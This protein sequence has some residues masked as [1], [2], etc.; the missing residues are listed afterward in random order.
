[1]AEQLKHSIAREEETPLDSAVAKGDVNLVSSL[2]DE[3]ATPESRGFPFSNTLIIA[4]KHGHVAVVNVLLEKNA[5]AHLESRE[6]PDGY[7][8][9]MW[10][11]MKGFD[12]IITLLLN[13]NANPYQ[14]LGRFYGKQTAL[15]LA[16]R[17]RQT[18]TVVLFQAIE[19][20]VLF[21]AS[22]KN[23]INLIQELLLNKKIDP[24]TK[25]EH[26]ET[27]LH[28]A[29][30]KGHGE[31]VALLI[32]HKADL[33]VTGNRDTALGMTP[34]HYAISE[35]KENC[36]MT[37]LIDHK[38]ELT[39]LDAFGNTP[40]QIA[41]SK[42]YDGTVEMLIRAKADVNTPNYSGLTPLHC[43]ARDGKTTTV[44]TLLKL[45]ADITASTA[46][47]EKIPRTA[48]IF[49]AAAGH[50]NIVQLLNQERS[51]QTHLAIFSG[52]HERTGRTE[53]KLDAAQ[54]ATL[55]RDA[56]ILAASRRPHFDK[57]IFE[58]PLKLAGFPLS[59]SVPKLPQKTALNLTTDTD[60]E[61]HSNDNRQE[62]SL[63]ARK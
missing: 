6:Y 34:L 51:R 45:R 40:L 61:H 44:K 30:R 16:F 5:S 22:E 29:A 21:R 9:L 28:Y 27:A 39:A 32:S 57:N 48:H 41:A 18:S 24:N 12:E 54:H 25:N 11:A 20:N 43:A 38:A 35:P 15:D 60:D 55:G 33:K 36:A 47:F 62:N 56:P 50:A 4:V 46:L 49:A 1:M 3:K 7:T 13:K 58:L 31:A 17:Q 2:L 52:M 10:A 23:D 14:T 42:G 53:A 19:T 59:R 63:T 8:A 37:V 26:G